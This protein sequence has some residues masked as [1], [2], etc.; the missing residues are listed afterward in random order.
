MNPFKAIAEKHSNADAYALAFAFLTAHEPGDVFAALRFARRCALYGHIEPKD[1]F[2]L[3]TR[4]LGNYLD[5]AL[6]TK[7]NVGGRVDAETW[8]ADYLEDMKDLATEFAK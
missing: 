3:G 5:G 7:W 1:G 8:V 2:K 4:T 6:F